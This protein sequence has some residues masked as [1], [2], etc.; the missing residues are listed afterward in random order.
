MIDVDV[1]DAGAERPRG[2]LWRSSPSFQR[3]IRDDARA[4]ALS[5]NAYIT[6]ALLSTIVVF[7]H[8]DAEGL[9][10][11]LLRL[12]EQMNASV[13][14]DG[15][16]LGACHRSDWPDIKWFIDVLADAE[17]VQGVKALDDAA[18][19][20][21]VYS[22]H[23]TREGR[24]VWRALGPRIANVIEM[25]AAGRAAVQAALRSMP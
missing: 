23:F 24:G 14:N 16:V 1:P 5:Q 20:T 6:S 15:N 10:E 9:P 13:G 12:I 11:N 8:R 7:G 2:V 4:F 21:A 25:C 22:F 3:R 18:P 19:E 17:L